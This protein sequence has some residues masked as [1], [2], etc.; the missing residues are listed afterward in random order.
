MDSAWKWPA[1]PVAHKS[2]GDVGQST[3]FTIPTEKAVH[4]RIDAPVEKVATTMQFMK[5]INEVDSDTSTSSWMQNGGPKTF[6]LD[7]TPSKVTYGVPKGHWVADWFVSPTVY[8]SITNGDIGESLKN[9]GVTIVVVSSADAVL[10]AHSPKPMGKDASGKWIKAPRQE[11]PDVRACVQEMPL[12]RAAFSKLVIWMKFEV[13]GL[14]CGEA[15][16]HNGSSKSQ[17]VCIVL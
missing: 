11:S 2:L 16:T 1:L 7:H 9:N 17:P 14:C 13:R 4:L 12:V 5:I 10:L 3:Y 15:L 6:P 8:D